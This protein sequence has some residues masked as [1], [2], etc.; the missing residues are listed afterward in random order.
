MDIHLLVISI[1]SSLASP[2]RESENAMNTSQEGY[3]YTGTVNTWT[4]NGI[5]NSGVAQA[6][7]ELQAVPS[8]TERYAN[9]SEQFPE[10]DISCQPLTPER[11]N[12]R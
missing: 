10:T 6:W 11:I 5:V 9:G 7:Q 3:R 2:S 12:L 4:E 8:Y 1:G